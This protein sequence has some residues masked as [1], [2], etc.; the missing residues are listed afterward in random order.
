MEQVI[1]VAIS[2]WPIVFAAVV[3]QGNVLVVLE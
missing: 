2:V 3:A 1:K